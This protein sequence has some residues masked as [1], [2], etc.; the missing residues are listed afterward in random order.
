MS[1]NPLPEPGQ[2]KA[3]GPINPPNPVPPG[4]P[5]DEGQ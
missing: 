1:S 5:A 3:P 4:V 2:P